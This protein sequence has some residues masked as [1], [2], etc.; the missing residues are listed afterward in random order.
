MTTGGACTFFTGVAAFGVGAGAGALAAAF[1]VEG[2]AAPPFAFGVA[3]DGAA[4]GFAAAAAGDAGEG[5][6]AAAGRIAG[7]P[8]R[9]GGIA[10]AFTLIFTSSPFYNTILTRASTGKAQLNADGNSMLRCSR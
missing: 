3:G 5:F 4:A 1:G 7:P 2:A 9:V 10:G 8:T 6:A